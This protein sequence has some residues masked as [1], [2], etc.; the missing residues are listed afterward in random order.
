MRRSKLR[1]TVPLL[2]FVSAFALAFSFAAVVQRESDALSL[3]ASQE[4]RFAPRVVSRIAYD[5]LIG[6]AFRYRLLT[7]AVA[8][9][10]DPV[11]FE[12][13]PPL[14]NS[15]RV[16]IYDFIKDNPGVQFRGICNELGMSVG[17]AQFHLGVL[18][19]AGLISFIRDGR[20]KRYFESKKFSEKEMMIISLLRCKTTKNIVKTLLGN[21]RASHGGL[22]SQLEITSQGMTWQMKR[23]KRAG[24]IQESKDGMKTI[25]SLEERHVPALAG[26]IEFM[27]P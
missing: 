14:N 23:L 16:D 18:K 10:F 4:N 19:K 7:F 3:S 21:G 22:A 27:E 2:V 9:T 11:A 6:P 13:P 20:Y 24:F 25:Y 17:L 12:E 1:L 26:I 5:S 8:S 15:T